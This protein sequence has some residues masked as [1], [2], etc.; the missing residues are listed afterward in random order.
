[1][2]D[3]CS[4]SIIFQ[5]PFGADR[6]F[7]FCALLS[8]RVFEKPN[9][10]FWGEYMK[11]IFLF[12]ILGVSL[13]FDS[14][15]AQAAQLGDVYLIW[16][17]G[18][19]TYE[20]TYAIRRKGDTYETFNSGETGPRYHGDL[21]SYK[22]TYDGWAETGHWWGIYAGAVVGG[23]FDKVI[24]DDTPARLAP[25]EVC[26]EQPDPCPTESDILAS[27]CGGEGTYYINE[28]TCEGHCTP[29]PECAEEYEQKVLLCGGADKIK[30]WDNTTC[31]G[32]CKS[33]RDKA[34][35]WAIDNCGSASYLADYENPT[36]DEDNNYVPPTAGNPCLT[37]ADAQARCE[38][39]CGGSGNIEVFT[40]NDSQSG[41]GYQHIDS[42]TCSCVQPAK[43]CNDFRLGCEQKCGG[44]GLIEAYYCEDDKDPSTRICNCPS[45]PPEDGTPLPTDTPDDP[46]TDPP[47]DPP[48]PG[49]DDSGLLS[50]IEQNTRST[51]QNTQAIGDQLAQA[52]QYQEWIGRN[53]KI[54]ADNTAQISNGINSLADSIDNLDLTPGEIDFHD[55]TAPILQDISD[56]SFTEPGELTS[57]EDGKEEYSFN[58][59]FNEFIGDMKTTGIFS[60]PNSITG[61]IPSGGSPV[62]AI[63]AGQYGSHDFDFSN[64]GNSLLVLRSV[65]LII[66][67]WVGIRIVLL[68]R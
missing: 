9:I 39:K 2:P 30:D 38:A 62:L 31:T 60:L 32:E 56:G 16:K 54:I 64:W 35:D 66:F 14:L 3:V 52:N 45:T 26:E 58:D 1:M 28:E 25:D 10:R 50:A 6:C 53:N 51:V 8:G 5:D 19:P 13:L 15:S 36:C 34:L 21:A 20:W 22:C 44:P 37:C 17:H 47:S 27:Q 29:T 65:C 46:G 11:L 61:S 7:V 18:D 63:D 57:Y 41:D 23:G 67:S 40:C 43:N 55:E 59:R 48:D 33:C 12:L 24:E 68:K 4:D 49:T 42:Y